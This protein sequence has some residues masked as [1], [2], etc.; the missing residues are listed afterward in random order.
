MLLGTVEYRFPITGKVQGAL[1]TDWGNAWEDKG[2]PDEV[3]GS[4]GA[5]LSLNTPLGPIRIDWGRGSQGSRVHFM[6]GNSF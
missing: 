6:V 4:F 3:H 1:F 2:A 5:G